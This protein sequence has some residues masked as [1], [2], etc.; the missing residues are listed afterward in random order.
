MKENTRKINKNI[1]IKNVIKKLQ[2]IFQFKLKSG[3]LS[4]ISPDVLTTN[5]NESVY[6][7][8]LYFKYNVSNTG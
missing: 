7:V 1:F 4:I 3:Y 6:L 2:K 8:K 5:N